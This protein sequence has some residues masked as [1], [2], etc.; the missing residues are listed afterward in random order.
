VVTQKS[1]CESK[2]T[3]EALIFCEKRE[4]VFDYFAEGVSGSI[5][6]VRPLVLEK[7]ATGRGRTEGR[8]QLEKLESF[9]FGGVLWGGVGVIS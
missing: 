5:Q 1:R 2:G 3:V 6:G 8:D 9:F 7:R 4:Y